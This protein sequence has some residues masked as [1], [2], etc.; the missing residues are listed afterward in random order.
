MAR[1]TIGQTPLES[2]TSLKERG[3]IPHEAVCSYAGR[4]DP[5]ASGLLLFLINEETKRRD[6]Y[7][8]LSKQYDFEV[9]FGIAT[10]TYDILGLVTGVSD[11][12]LVMEK[13]EVDNIVHEI[14][15]TFVQPY[16]PY[17][18]ALVDG[19]PL[20][21]WARKEELHQH[22]IPT[23]EVT[24]FEISVDSITQQS[25][26]E[27]KAL[28]NNRVEAVNGDFR[29][30]EIIHNWNFQ[31]ADDTA[32]L[33]AQMH[34]VVSSGTYIRSIAHRL[35]QKLGVPSLAFSITRSS[36]GNIRL[37]SNEE[38]RY[39]TPEELGV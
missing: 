1:K 2:I 15:G 8:Q 28:V 3:V 34:A 13:A 22:T 38:Y 29:Q 19:K 5:M 16:P 25:G 4:L 26:A 32:F 12:P 20:W 17:S 39:V 9:L 7:E 10:D 21:E 14:S 27:I 35:G 24:I 11:T 37:E 23:K 31:I 36:I 30:E 6:R 33:I 18:S